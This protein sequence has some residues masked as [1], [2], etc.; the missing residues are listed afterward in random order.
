MN[1]EKSDDDS[2]MDLWSSTWEQQC[3]QAIET[4]TD[5]ETQLHSEREFYSQLLWAN[6]QTTATAIAQLYKGNF[7]FLFIK[8]Q[9]AKVGHNI[10]YVPE[11][12]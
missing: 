10:Y 1:E 11:Y 4:G 7:F 5:F 8:L 3:V 9:R 6:F 2:I 12:V